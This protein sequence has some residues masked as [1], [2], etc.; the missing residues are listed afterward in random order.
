MIPAPLQNLLDRL[1]VA[2]HERAIALKAISFAMVGVVN[3]G[4]DFSIFWTT[5]TYLQWPLVPANML[6]WLVAVSF[7]YAMNS[8]TTFGPESGRILRWRDYATFVASG[9][10]GMVASTATLVALSY[11]LPL[12]LAKLLSILVSFVV[13][14][15]L[16][17][18]VV[19]KARKPRA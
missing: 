10:A 15:S 14:F 17:H 19:F 8:F 11:V 9:I 13:N 5:V 2:W 7:S 18:F 16:S 3:T 4:I 12:L 1:S 6:S